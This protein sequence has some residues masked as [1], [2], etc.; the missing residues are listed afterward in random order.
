MKVTSKP[1]TK[2]PKE[3]KPR[4]YIEDSIPVEV[5]DTAY[6]K[7]LVRDGSLQ[8]ANLKPQAKR[9]SKPDGKKDK[10]KG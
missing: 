3:G 10:G 4:Q 5:P 7:R 2:C 1:G 9:S 8:I 6:Y